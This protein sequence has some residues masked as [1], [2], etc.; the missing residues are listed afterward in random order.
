M[1]SRR[2]IVVCLAFEAAAFA[3]LI[4]VLLDR[5]AH[6]RDP[7]YGVNQWGYRGAARGE[8]LP[9]ELRVALVGGSAAYEPG[10][11]LEETM[12]NNLLYQLQEVGRPLAI[13][14][15][16]VNLSEPGAGADAYVDTL[17]EYE[18]LGADVT[19]IFDGYDV[20]HGV[21]PHSRQHSAIFRAVGYLPLLP[22]RILGGPGWMSDPDGGVVQLLRADQT[23]P[24]DVTC[25]GAS[26][27]YCAAIA[28]TVR[29]ALAR[30]RPIVVASPPSVSPRHAAQQQS[31]GALLT[32]TFASDPRFMYLDTG[33]AIDL[34]NRAHSPDGLHRTVAGNHE[35][36]QRIAVGILHLLARL[37]VQPH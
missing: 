24:G 7:V 25:E 8:R 22:S 9:R 37:N 14:Y 16:I 15:S 33:D 35:V 20:L 30:N 32:R 19:C 31:L 34:S 29:F 17:R 12:S 10:R 2:S 27:G 36:G 18:F 23:E 1:L 21:A 28:D 26:R 5:R 13:E 3:F 4:G 6:Q 11:T